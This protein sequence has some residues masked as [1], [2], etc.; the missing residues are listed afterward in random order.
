MLYIAGIGMTG[1]A[2]FNQQPKEV[3]DNISESS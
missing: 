1:Y 2:L 3:G